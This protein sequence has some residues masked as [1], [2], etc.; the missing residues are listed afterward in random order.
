MTLHHLSVSLSAALFFGL[1]LTAMA[2]E[3]DRVAPTTLRFLANGTQQ[4]DSAVLS[5]QSLQIEFDPIRL[6]QC[7][8]K[9]KDG[10]E[11]WTVQAFLAIDGEAPLALDLIEGRGTQFPYAVPL[12]VIIPDGK[13]LDVWFKASDV[14]GC[15]QWD[16]N[17]S[18]NYSFAITRLEDI[19]VISF[20]DNWKIEQKGVL[21]AGQPVRLHYDLSRATQCRTG[22]YHGS[23]SWDVSAQFRVDGQPLAAQALTY[24]KSWSERGQQDIVT[25]LPE[26]RELTLWFENSGYEYYAGRA[27]KAYD[28]N[29]GQNYHFRL[30]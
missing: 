13:R 7:R 17:S 12:S 15:V 30:Y 23:A 9:N 21:K 24:T 6:N 11:D 26:G 22:G 3:S 8:G 28:S 5:G 16:S 19:P 18:Q 25:L 2:A 10:V 27:C 20:Y 29:Y 4:F 1:S 14:N